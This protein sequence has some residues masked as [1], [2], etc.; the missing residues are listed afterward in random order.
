MLKF[1]YV[2][3]I[4]FV[5][6]LWTMFFKLFSTMVLIGRS[7]NLSPIDRMKVASYLVVS[8]VVILEILWWSSI[9]TNFSFSRVQFHKIAHI[10]VSLIWFH[11]YLSRDGIDFSWGCSPN[12]LWPY[13][14]KHTRW[15]FSRYQI[16][17]PLL[18]V[19]LIWW[20]YLCPVLLIWWYDYRLFYLLPLTT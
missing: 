13:F 1:I 11:F 15:W 6:K 19:I 20:L 12:T 14:G 10:H 9:S 4:I 18:G 16:V 17:T 7:I 5:L 2:A 8:W 3:Q